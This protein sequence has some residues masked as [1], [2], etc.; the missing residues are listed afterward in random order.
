MPS[1]SRKSF[2]KRRDDP[3]VVR[4]DSDTPEPE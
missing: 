3:P 2:R 4:V 1:V